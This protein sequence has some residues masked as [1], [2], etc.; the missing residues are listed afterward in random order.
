MENN[1]NINQTFVFVEEFVKFNLITSIALLI[2]S[3][4]VFVALLFYH[5]KTDKKVKKKFS[6]LTLESK[7][8]LLSK[9]TCMAIAFFSLYRNLNAIGLFIFESQVNAAENSTINDRNFSESACNVLSKIGNFALSF[10]TGLVYLFLWIRQRV[11]YV[12]PLLKLLN[13]G[14]TRIISS[15]IIFFWLTFYAGFGLSYVVIVQYYYNQECLIV[16]ST[17]DLYA[18]LVIS[19]VAVTLFMQLCLL[20][21]FIYP[22]LNQAFLRQNSA[23]EWNSKLLARVKKAIVL[24]AVCLLSD[25]FSSALAYYTYIPN[26]TSLFSMFSINLTINHLA[27]IGC[28]NKWKTILFPWNCSYWKKRK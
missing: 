8:A 24:T 17:V 25:I 9:Y 3:T 12:H 13:N 15:S 26:A 1:V 7:Y 18:N 27:T 10:G 16:E 5:F 19:Y 11:L 20:G 28:F 6:E 21:L 22:I 2:V 4:Y 14:L 23:V